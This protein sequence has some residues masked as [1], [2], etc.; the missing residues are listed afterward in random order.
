MRLNILIGGKAGQGI[1][2]VSSI[3][4]NILSKY[5]YYT[6]NYRDYPSLIR[7]GHNFNI[8]SISD[9]KVGS[10]ESEL[11]CIIA[12]DEKTNELHK[13]ELKKTGFVI[14]CDEFCE[15]GKNANIAQAGALIKILGIDNNLL[16]EEIKKQFPN[17][18]E[19]IEAAKRGYKN[20]ESKFNL[21]KLNNNIKIMTGSHAVAIGAVDSGIDIYLSYPM[22]P[23][24][25]VLHELAARQIENNFLVFQPENEIAVANAGLCASFAGAKTM[26]GTSGGGYDLM[27]EALSFQGMS[28]I[29]L[30]VYLASRPGPGSQVNN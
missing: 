12:L 22:T 25:A 29:P 1:N 21:K 17:N 14:G 9:S 2:K 4:S 16:I 26:I 15:I 7:G 6:F 28:E 5:G 8:L 3:I 24:T 13:K 11:D 20:K 19:A 18:K 23:A 27:T 10:I 30:V